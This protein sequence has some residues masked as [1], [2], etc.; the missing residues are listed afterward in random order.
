MK[1]ALAFLGLGALAIVVQG[2]LVGVFPARWC[3]DLGFL[4]V[5][6]LGTRW[7]SSGGG[8]VIS[9]ALGYLADLL[10]GSLLG[11]HLLL[12]MFAYAAARRANP[13]DTSSS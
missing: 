4:M 13:S 2:A 12:R 9:A 10:S 5:I 6:G 3:P 11:Q 7:R 8:L 1:A